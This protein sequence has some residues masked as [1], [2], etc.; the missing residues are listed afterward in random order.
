MTSHLEAYEACE[1]TLDLGD[2]LTSRVGRAE[3]L[4]NSRCGVN[5]TAVL[6]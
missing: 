3:E 2:G 6:K 1:A 4:A 5:I